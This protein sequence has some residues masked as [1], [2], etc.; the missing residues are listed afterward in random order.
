MLTIREN[1]ASDLVDVDRSAA[2]GLLA[3]RFVRSKKA[4]HNEKIIERV[5]SVKPGTHHCHNINSERSQTELA[6]YRS[7]LG[8]R[9]GSLVA[10]ACYRHVPLQRRQQS[11]RTFSELLLLAV[12]EKHER[13]GIGAS[14]V[15]Y[16]KGV[17]SQAGSHILLVRV[18]NIEQP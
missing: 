15:E 5:L 9:N 12:H 11:T 7:A 18:V 16:V 8:F 1:R 4:A 2:F 10:V 3:S 6:G 17:S 14:M 13:Q